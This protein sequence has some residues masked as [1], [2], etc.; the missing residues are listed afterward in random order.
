LVGLEASYQLLTSYCWLSYQF[1]ETFEQ[2][3]LAKKLQ[4]KCSKVIE[5]ILSSGLIKESKINKKKT[6][7]KEK[8]MRYQESIDIE[9]RK[10][11]L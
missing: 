2:R 6:S 1:E 7:K 5:R 4:L 10:F 3:E 8:R 9:L 11:G